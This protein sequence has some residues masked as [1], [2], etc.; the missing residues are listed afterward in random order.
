MPIEINLH[1]IKK[2]ILEDY[3]GD[4]ELIASMVIGGMEQKTKSRIRNAE[5]F[6]IYINAKDVD[7]DSEEVNYTGW[8]NKLSI[9]EFNKTSRSE[10][11][12]STDI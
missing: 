11:R 9:P 8:L 10:Y 12:R 3:T 7:Y 1:D 5:G 6:E 2:K 4:F